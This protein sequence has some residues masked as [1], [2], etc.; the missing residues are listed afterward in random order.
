[1]MPTTESNVIERGDLVAQ[2]TGRAR[3]LRD[4]GEIKSPGTLEEAARSLTN[5]RAVVAAANALLSD[6]GTPE[7][8]MQANL[9]RDL[10]AA[11]A[12]TL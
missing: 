2:I 10:R 1:M 4:R 11:I 12:K 8:G 9:M 3:F 6:L 7:D 5:H